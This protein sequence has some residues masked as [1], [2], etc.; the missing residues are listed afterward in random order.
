VGAEGGGASEG[1]G[2]YVCVRLAG[3]VWLWLLLLLGGDVDVN[4]QGRE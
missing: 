1:G 3:R 2:V 4:G